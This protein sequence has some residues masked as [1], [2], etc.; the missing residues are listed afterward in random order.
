MLEWGRTPRCR[1]CVLS[2]LAALLHP[3][4]ILSCSIQA[5]GHLRWYLETRVFPEHQLLVGN[6]QSERNLRTLGRVSASA[7]SITSLL[8]PLGGHLLTVLMDTSTCS[9]LAAGLMDEQ[10]QAWS[11]SHT[12]NWLIGEIDIGQTMT[13]M[14]ADGVEGPGTLC[15]FLDSSFHPHDHHPQVTH[16]ASCS[17]PFSWGTVYRVWNCPA[18][19]L[20][21]THP[22]HNDLITETRS[23]L[24][25]IT[26]YSSLL[27]ETKLR[28]EKRKRVI[29]RVNIFAK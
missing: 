15:L 16:L 4:I 21:R 11:L 14:C 25:T 7:Q 20:P 28:K 26:S 12:T 9:V 23:I 18:P 17:W 6:C 3:A 13:P 29:Q 1:V 19:P 8:L 5:G 10:N 27:E 24:F 2:N 22:I